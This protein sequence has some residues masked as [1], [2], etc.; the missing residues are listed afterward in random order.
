ME[1]RRLVN[2]FLYLFLILLTFVYMSFYITGP[3]SYLS[4]FLFFILS[5]QIVIKFLTF[6]KYNIKI[7]KKYGSKFYK[8]LSNFLMIL[9][10]V[11]LIFARF[12]KNWLIISWL[13]GLIAYYLE[14]KQI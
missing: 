11:T 1:K 8:N 10:F 12:N 4:I 3:L 5:I 6:K 14:E 9:T 2:M 13:T 7:I